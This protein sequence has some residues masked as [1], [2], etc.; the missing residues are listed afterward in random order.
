ETD[1]PDGADYQPH[2]PEVEDW[3][4]LP[5]S[6]AAL[7][8]TLAGS[9]VMLEGMAACVSV[10]LGM[11]IEGPVRIDYILG[12]PGF[13][14]SALL[15]EQNPALHGFWDLWADGVEGRITGADLP[16]LF[17][18]S[19]SSPEVEGLSLDAQAL[20][21]KTLGLLDWLKNLTGYLIRMA[22]RDARG[23]IEN[24]PLWPLQPF[25]LPG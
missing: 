2:F 24:P 14:G 3:Y 5:P 16:E 15:D 13:L 7:I 23:E 21:E 10:L 4:A 6:T 8:T 9:H 18:R 11:E 1:V 17:S 19:L 12:T 25:V 20:T 22:D